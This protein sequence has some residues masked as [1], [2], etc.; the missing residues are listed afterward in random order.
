MG[1][2]HIDILGNEA[3][4]AAAKKAAEGV[5]VNDHE[6]WVRMGKGKRDEVGQLGC[7]A[8]REVGENGGFGPCYVWAM[9]A[10]RL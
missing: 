1:K 10:G 8:I 6:K 4:D 7:I 5:P 3:A 9:K 2:S